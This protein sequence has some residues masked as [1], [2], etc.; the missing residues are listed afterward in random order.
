MGS[1]HHQNTAQRQNG[2]PQTAHATPHSRNA[3]VVTSHHCHYMFCL[4]RILDKFD[5]VVFLLNIAVFVRKLA[6]LVWALVIRMKQVRRRPRRRA[7]W[8][9]FAH[10]FQTQRQISF[11][12]CVVHFP[13]QFAVF[14]T[15]G[16]TLQNARNMRAIH[17]KLWWEVCCSEKWE[18]WIWEFGKV[19]SWKTVATF[20][21]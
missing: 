21:R 18:F 10:E 17:P 12:P 7:L 2:K 11:Q 20:S 19:G 8:W 6:V 4:V 9:R 5:I 3:S 15:S 1:S 16:R 14:A 13:K